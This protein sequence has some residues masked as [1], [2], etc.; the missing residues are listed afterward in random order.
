[1]NTLDGARPTIGLDLGTTNSCVTFTNALGEV[2]PV[3]VATGNAPYDRVIASIVLDPEADREKGVFPVLGL[4]A[5]Q[6][7]ETKKTG[8]YLEYFKHNLDSHRL[9]QRTRVRKPVRTSKFNFRTLSDEEAYVTEWV[10]SGGEYSREEMVSA[11]AAL[12]EHLLQRA[13]AAGAD[14]DSQILVG[15]PV[16]YSGYARKRL[17]CAL[18]RARDESGRRIFDGFSDVIRR[19][20]FVLEPIAVAA[21]PGDDLDIDGVENVLIFDHGGGTLDLSLIRYERRPE[22]RLPVPVLELA[23]GGSDEVAGKHLDLAFSDRLHADPAIKRTLEE[24][25][26]DQTMRRHVIERSKRELSTSQE[27][28]IPVA[29]VPVTRNFFEDSILMQLYEIEDEINGTMRRGGIEASEVGWVVMTGGSSLVP[30]VQKTVMDLF[31][32][33]AESDRI[34]RYFPDDAGGVEAA[35]TDVSEGLAQY[36]RQQSLQRIVPWDI[37]V[38]REEDGDFFGIIERGEQYTEQDGHMEI[39][40]KV[41]APDIGR[42]GCSFG[43][44]EKQLDYQFT[45]GLAEVPALPEGSRLVVSI[46]PD[47]LFPALRIEGPDGHVITRPKSPSG[48][49]QDLKVDADFVKYPE[50]VLEDFFEEDGEYVPQV[51]PE[52]FQHA[53]LVRKLRVGDYVDVSGTVG[54]SPGRGLNK[55]SRSGYIERIRRLGED[56]GMDEMDGWNVEEFEFQINTG[57]SVMKVETRNGCIRLSPK[58]WPHR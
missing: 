37:C 54:S 33:L 34:L 29:D 23:A 8:T 52:K 58:K 36:G 39:A 56:G 11:A 12:F 24:R 57:R 35:I 32:E 10:E 49:E 7:W 40:R 47:S 4:A 31:P 15:V 2:V 48:W 53:P 26:P 51:G 38:G 21:A 18:V 25:V 9:K 28:R 19:T 30:S 14:P 42:P 13:F 16:A 20:K 22:F 41:E 55:I 43:I 45:F 5:E 27:A 44:Y 3:S 46:R 17:V 1:M 6:Q 50:N